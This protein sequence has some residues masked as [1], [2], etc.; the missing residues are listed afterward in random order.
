MREDIKELWVAAL[1]SGKYVQ[2]QGQLA[3]K[4]NGTVKFC[5][6]GVLCQVLVDNKLLDITVA[7]KTGYLTYDG[8]GLTLPDSVVQF[9]ELSE[10]NPNVQF[11]GGLGGKYNENAVPLAGMND[12]NENF[13]TIADAIERSL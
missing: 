11:D 4:D 8:A 7:T 9:C 1:R 12:Y 6:L 13:P 10:N 3:T 5:C 2:G